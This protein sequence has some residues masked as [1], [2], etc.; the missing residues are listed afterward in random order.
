[1]CTEPRQHLVFAVQ[2]LQSKASH[3]IS[4]KIRLR[5]NRSGVILVILY[6]HALGLKFR[7][8]N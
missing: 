2:S 8:K 7:V 4:A 6:A 1:M 5:D 3:F